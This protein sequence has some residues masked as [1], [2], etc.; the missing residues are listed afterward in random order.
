[1]GSEDPFEEVPETQPTENNNLPNFDLGITT[2]DFEVHSQ[3]DDDNDD[4]DPT[5]CRLHSTGM[6]MDDGFDWFDNKCNRCLQ[7]KG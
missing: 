7:Y 5:L 3:A 1:M 2:K 4:D 6:G